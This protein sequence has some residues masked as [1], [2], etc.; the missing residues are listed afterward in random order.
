VT[1]TD[2]IEDWLL[3][4]EEENAA[5]PTFRDACRYGLVAGQL[6]CDQTGEGYWPHVTTLLAQRAERGN[7]MARVCVSSVIDAPAAELW[8]RI[9]DFNGTNGLSADTVGCVREITQKDGLKFLEV[10]VMLSHVDHTYSYTFV[11]SPIPVKGHRTT[12]WLLPV[13]DGNRTYFEWTSEFDT[14]PDSEA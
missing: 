1:Q 9:G 8:R 13:T 11:G 2:A 12:I 7:V 4:I 10:L 5:R 6:H 3:T 14:D